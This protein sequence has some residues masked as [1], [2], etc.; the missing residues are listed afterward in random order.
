[1]N[2]LHI[3]PKKDRVKMVGTDVTIRHRQREMVNGHFHAPPLLTPVLIG[4]NA[5]WTLLHNV[6]QGLG[7]EAVVWMNEI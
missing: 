4:Q 5:V 6:R 1:M 7:H 3:S 2:L